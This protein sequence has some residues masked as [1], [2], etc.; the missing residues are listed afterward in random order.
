MQQFK[1]EIKKKVIMKITSISLLLYK[2]NFIASFQETVAIV[3]VIANRH[4]I[5][6]KVKFTGSA[7]SI[8]RL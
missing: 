8:K 6:D 7:E 4:H 1:E 3:D 5:S 2:K